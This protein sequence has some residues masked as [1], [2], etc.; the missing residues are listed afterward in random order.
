MLR[1]GGTGVALQLRRVSEQ[2][3]AGAGQ[4][5]RANLQ[6]P[7]FACVQ[8]VKPWLDSPLVAP[9]AS[10]GGFGTVGLQATPQSSGC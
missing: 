2:G 8:A 1:P 9:L 10:L 7:V 5:V 3:L 6:R 4:V